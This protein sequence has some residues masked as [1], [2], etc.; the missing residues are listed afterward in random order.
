MKLQKNIEEGFYEKIK[1]VS[2]YGGV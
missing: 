2:I 1:N